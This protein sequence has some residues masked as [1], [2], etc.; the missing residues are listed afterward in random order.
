LAAE[1]TTWEKRPG[2][3]VYSSD[4]SPLTKSGLDQAFNRARENIPNLAGARWHGLR[5]NRVVE[6]RRR[7]LTTLQIQDLVGMSA[8]EVERYCRFADKKTN[9][10]ATIIKFGGGTNRNRNAG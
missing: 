9:A 2:P 6:L 10:M 4:G 8:K 7:G 3:F 1:M 5:A